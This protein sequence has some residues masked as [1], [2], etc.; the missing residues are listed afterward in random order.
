MITRGSALELSDYGIRVN[1]VAPGQIATEFAEGWA[2]QARTL[3]EEDGFIKPIPL[4]RVGKPEDVSGAVLFL[5][6]ES[7]SY[8]TGVLLPVDG[9]WQII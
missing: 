6:S 4:N 7:A 2:E 1:A 3:Q 5:A 9:G 8:I